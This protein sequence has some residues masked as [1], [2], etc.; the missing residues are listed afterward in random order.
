MHKGYHY[1]CIIYGGTEQRPRGKL[2][3]VAEITGQ[4]Q[5]ILRLN[6][7]KSY[8]ITGCFLLIIFSRIVTK[9]AFM[10]VLRTLSVCLTE[11]LPHGF[12]LRVLTI[13]IPG[14]E[15]N[16]KLTSTTQREGRGE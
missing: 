11:N 7:L 15:Q 13:E 5:S 8:L 9:P 12:R 10:M 3:A 6:L 2:R 14:R 16:F 4:K 1:I